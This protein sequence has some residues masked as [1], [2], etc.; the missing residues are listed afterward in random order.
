L[1]IFTSGNYSKFY[2]FKAL[3][4]KQITGVRYCTPFIRKV[5]LIII[6]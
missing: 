1:K 3:R 4:E 2:I 5:D 6:K